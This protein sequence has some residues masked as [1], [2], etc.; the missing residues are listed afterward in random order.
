MKQLN[1][2][3]QKKLNWFIIPFGIL[4]IIFF[5][6][7]IQDNIS[8]YME[9]GRYALLASLDIYVIAFAAAC[10]KEKCWGLFT[11]AILFFL[12]TWARVWIDYYFI[13]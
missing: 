5:V 6:N 1:K 9:W 12:L 10:V 11:V 8:D 3:T 13:F 2:D 7:L 4:L